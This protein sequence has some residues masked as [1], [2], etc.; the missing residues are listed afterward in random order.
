MLVDFSA[1][2]TFAPQFA[3]GVP[4]TGHSMQFSVSAVSGSYYDDNDNLVTYSCQ[5]T[6]A[7]Q[8][9]YMDP[10]SFAFFEDETVTD[11]QNGLYTTNVTLWDP[12][13]DV[14]FNALDL[15]VY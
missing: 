12:Y 15:D 13:A 5:C 6:D 11:N 10:T 3:G 7:T 4:I 8:P 14:T 9:N 2:L 1:P